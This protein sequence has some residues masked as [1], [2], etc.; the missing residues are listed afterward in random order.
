MSRS[1]EAARGTRDGKPLVDLNSRRG[2]GMRCQDISSRR[3]DAFGKTHCCGPDLVLM[4][5]EAE[6]RFFIEAIG[7]SGEGLCLQAGTSGE[8]RRSEAKAAPGELRLGT[9]ARVGQME[10]LWTCIGPATS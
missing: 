2:P 1:A 10:V 3:S 5:A 8:S 7:T 6:R 9:H 4:G